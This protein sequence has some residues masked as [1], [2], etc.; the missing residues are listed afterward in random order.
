M[1]FTRR[2]AVALALGVETPWPCDVAAADRQPAVAASA[3]IHAD[4]A[5]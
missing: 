2:H 4:A 5:D 3:G 1:N